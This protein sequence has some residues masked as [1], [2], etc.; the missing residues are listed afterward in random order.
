[1]D[2]VVSGFDCNRWTGG[3]RKGRG[4]PRPFSPHPQVQAVVPQQH[5]VSQHPDV[6][7]QVVSFFMLTSCG[8]LAPPWQDTIPVHSTRAVVGSIRTLPMGGMTFGELMRALAE[9]EPWPDLGICSAGRDEPPQLRSDCLED[10]GPVTSDL[11]PCERAHARFC[12]SSPMSIDL[13]NAG[14]RGGKEAGMR[15]FTALLRAIQPRV[16]IAHGTATRVDLE[17][18]VG[19]SLPKPPHGPQD[20][21]ATKSGT[22]CNL[23][24][25]LAG[26]HLHVPLTG[27]HQTV[28][29]RQGPAAYASRGVF[30]KPY[31]RRFSGSRDPRHPRDRLTEASS[32]SGRVRRQ[33]RSPQGPTATS[34]DLG[35]RPPR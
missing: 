30:P 16:I 14:D 6:Q 13:R 15:I 32:T 17:K 26:A 27:N 9:P 5:P 31:S 8:V 21:V 12:Y 33:R 22:S 25:F 10:T 3:K 35:E 28:H 2:G 29:A 24:K 20:E 1:M 19:T 23:P 34:P 7:P 11:C 18:I 4:N